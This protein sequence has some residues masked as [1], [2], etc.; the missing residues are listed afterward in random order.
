M[1][2]PIVL[3]GKKC[4]LVPIEKDDIDLFYKW[5]NDI[6]VSRGLSIVTELPLT[7]AQEEKWF[8]EKV[9][10]S[11]PKNTIFAIKDLASEKIIGNVSLEGHELGIVIGDKDFWGQGYGPEAI[12]LIMDFGFNELNMESVFL[13]VADFNERAKKA[14]GKIGFKEAGRLRQNV[15]HAGKWHDMY[16]MDIL[17]EE[18]TARNKSQLE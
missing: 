2:H 18:Y 15:F 7:H 4:A 10:K 9:T 6:E 17:K 1:A 13:R 5:L 16:I 12:I 14:Y 11:D 8:E 3:K